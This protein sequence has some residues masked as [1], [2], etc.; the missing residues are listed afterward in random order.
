MEHLALEET[1]ANLM[2]P[3]ILLEVE[4]EAATQEVAAEKDHVAPM[5]LVEVEVEVLTS[6]SAGRPSLHS[7]QHLW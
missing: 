2:A 5:S 7:D 4:A 3:R 6:S 1:E